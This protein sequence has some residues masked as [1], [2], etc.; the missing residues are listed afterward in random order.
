MRKFIVTRLRNLAEKNILCSTLLN[1]LWCLYWAFNFKNLYADKTLTYDDFSTEIL[2]DPPPLSDDRTNFITRVLLEEKYE[3]IVEIGAYNLQRSY[4]YKRLFPEIE[5][6]ALDKISGFEA[7]EERDGIK[8]GLF[9][10]GWFKNHK[11]PKTLVISCGTLCYFKP[12]DLRS[13]FEM[14]SPHGYDLALAE[15]GSHFAKTSSLRRSVI[16]YH[17]P[18]AHLLSNAGFSVNAGHPNHAFSLSAIA[19]REYILA[20]SKPAG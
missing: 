10:I 20:T 14:L 9:D 15:P 13:F 2:K 6:V 7:A 16:S 3:R 4:H 8:T 19:R 1:R 12:N 18:Y 17:H 5:V 11:G